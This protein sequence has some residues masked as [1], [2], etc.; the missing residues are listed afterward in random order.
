M[1]GLTDERHLFPSNWVDAGGEMPHGA[2]AKSSTGHRTRCKRD[3]SFQPLERRCTWSRV[4]EF[5]G[6]H[7]A[8]DKGA[9]AHPRKSVGATS[10]AGEATPQ[11]S[12]QGHTFCAPINIRKNAA[13]SLTCRGESQLEGDAHKTA[14]G[15]WQ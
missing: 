8:N 2:H 1:E 9:P 7:A 3:R 6:G 13:F 4:D 5:G 10:C 12:R 15:G 14:S 11:P